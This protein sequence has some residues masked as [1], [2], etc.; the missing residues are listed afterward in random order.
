MRPAK[1]KSINGKDE[2]VK[3]LIVGAFP[4]EAST[5][6]GGIRRSC[7]L[8]IKSDLFDDF[9]IIKLD[10]TQRSLP[11]PRF[12]IRAFFSLIRIFKLLFT[13]MVHRPTLALIFCSNGLSAV[14]KGLFI[15]IC[16]L[17]GTKPL[18]FPRAGKLIEE[19]ETNVVFQ[20]VINF[21]FR[22]AQLFVCQGP[23]WQTF[24]SDRLKIP[25]YKIVIVN[26]WSATDDHLE[27]GRK[28]IKRKVNGQAKILFIGWLVKPKGIQELIE[29]FKILVKRDLNFKVTLVGDGEERINI[30]NQLSK[31]DFSHRIEVLGWKS[32]RDLLP[33]FASHDIFVLP[34]WHEGMPNAMIE[35]MACRLS[36]IV[37]PVGIIPNYLEDGVH[38]RF[39]KPGNVSELVGAFE[40]Q[41]LDVQKSEKMARAAMLLAKQ[42]FSTSGELKSLVR[43]LNEVQRGL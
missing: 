29:A 22:R 16:S 32:D 34:S 24:A 41:I 9:E 31:F 38:G 15:V 27:I 3:L 19:Y 18:I 11:P 10:S 26:N 12:P 33:I 37:T 43:S 40:E 17:F 1:G 36:P 6:F 21:L 13:L 42:K 39:V 25:N 8:I 30:V 20:V 28:R 35:A 23:N 4:K 2:N 7:E 5:V 14:E